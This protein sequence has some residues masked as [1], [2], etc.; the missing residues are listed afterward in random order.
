MKTRLVE[1]EENFKDTTNYMQENHIT[2]LDAN[3]IMKNHNLYEIS[4]TLG[5]MLDIMRELRKEDNLD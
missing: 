2:G 5:E 1:I 3:E 4:R